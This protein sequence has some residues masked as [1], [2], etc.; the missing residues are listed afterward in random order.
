MNED[1]NDIKG[2]IFVSCVICLVVG[3]VIGLLIKPCP[4]LPKP[5]NM[6]VNNSIIIQDV[7]GCA[8]NTSM[9]CCIY[10]K[11]LPGNVTQGLIYRCDM[12]RP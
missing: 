11:I 9:D 10:Y 3:A 6:S 12:Q 7:S 5:Q 2:L 1:E 4:E 8:Y